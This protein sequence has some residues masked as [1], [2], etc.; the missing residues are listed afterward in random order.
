MIQVEKS[1]VRQFLQAAQYFSLSVPYI[2][3][4]FFPSTEC[5]LPAELSLGV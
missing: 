1:E 4:F 5:Q 2:F 3:Q